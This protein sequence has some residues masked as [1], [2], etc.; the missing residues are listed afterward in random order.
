MQKVDFFYPPLS[1]FYMSRA[2]WPGTSLYLPTVGQ[3][4]GFREIIQPSIRKRRG[5]AGNALSCG[6][7]AAFLCQVPRLAAVVT[8]DFARLAALYGDMAD[9]AAPGGVGVGE[10]ENH[11]ISARKRQPATSF[12][13]M[14]AKELVWKEKSGT[15]GDTA[16][17]YSQFAK[18]SNYVQCAGQS[19]WGR[20]V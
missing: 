4:R 5:D 16:S 10:S 15:R 1:S 14:A 13:S 17:L 8:V 18:H 11:S 19:C 2:H 3:W 20:V 7:D 12:F 6:L 9:L